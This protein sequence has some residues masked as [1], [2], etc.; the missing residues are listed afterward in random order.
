MCQRIAF[1]IEQLVR[2]EL[3]CMRD[4]S[5]Q[6]VF[7]S[8]AAGTSDPP[9]DEPEAGSEPWRK[10]RG[11][12]WRLHKH[13]ARHTRKHGECKHPDVEAVEFKCPGCMK[14]HPRSSDSHNY[15][16]DCRHALTSSRTGVRKRPYA[17]VKADAEPTSKLK[18]S[19][20]GK[21]DEAAAE[22]AM[23]PEPRPAAEAAEPAQASDA[24]GPAELRPVESEALVP[25]D[26]AEA[27]GERR[28]RGPDTVA[29][30]RRT[31]GESETQTPVPADWS[32]FDIGS[33]LRG[34]KFA[35][36]DG[37]R[38]ILRKLH[39]RWW[40]ISAHRMKAVLQ[41]AGISG[42]ILEMIDSIVDTC[43]IC[44]TWARPAADAV[45]SSRIITGFNVEVEGDLIF[46]KTMRK[47]H[48]ILHLVDR[49]TRWAAGYLLEDKTT[50]EILRGLDLWIGTFGPMQ[51]LIF[52]GEQGLQDDEARI[53]F[54]IKGITKRT[55]AV[56]QHTRIVDRRTQVL[57]DTMHKVQSQL[58]EEG[59]QV[60][61]SRIL[62]EAVYA[63]NALTSVNGYSPF[64]AV[65]GRVPPMLPD[66]MAVADD[67]TG[68]PSSAHTHRL[69]EIAIQAIVEGTARD[70]MKRAL[71]TPTRMAGEELELRVGEEVEYFRPP[72]NKDASGWRGP[73]TVVDLTRLEH[74]RIGIRTRA[75]NVISCRVQDIRRCL[76]SWAS[77]SSMSQ[78]ANHAQQVA[79]EAID[80][81]K[82]GTMITIGQVRNPKGEWCMSTTTKQHQGLYAAA[83]HVAEN[84]FNIPNAVAAR[85]GF[86]VKHLPLKD[87]YS[88][89][90]II[91]WNKLG[92][93]A[94]Q[95]FQSQCTAV[96]ISG[97][98]GSEWTNT[99]FIQLL[100][101]PD[102]ED[103]LIGSHRGHADVVAP[104]VDATASASTPRGGLD[105]GGPLSTI[106]EGSNESGTEV[107]LVT[108]EDLNQ[109]FGVGDDHP[110]IL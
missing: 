40:H 7:P 14:G 92:T 97:L 74:G 18:A 31:Y 75:D 30:V 10:C 44:R 103:W 83:M 82:K 62:A 87:E 78:G 11:C 28:G 93:R 51:V 39:V 32:S 53:Y 57:R 5:T 15:G 9:G 110:A 108:F 65:L 59:V 38:R 63:T 79:Q 85:C 26:D 68:A 107:S 96:S 22:D 36:E 37:Q 94:L 88:G 72:E 66:V 95:F 48:P 1:G 61:I 64:T 101:A 100:Q 52:D 58:S 23:P 69:R 56:G 2:S 73:A 46:Y 12:L 25:V 60:P 13:D 45:S 16:P 91:H 34:I 21:R 19:D 55:A 43:R 8:I 89:S 86:G 76:S 6:L 109:T 70:R 106:Q 20:L 102:N 80:Q 47:L 17:R 42:K 77:P 67:T 27:S 71:H 105:V 99:R 29:R 24:A 98:T 3:K 54:E 35:N 4:S 50:S 81:F 49:G 90:L 84:V 104:D 41:K 33:S